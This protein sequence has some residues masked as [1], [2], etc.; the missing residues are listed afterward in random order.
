[1]IGTVNLCSL[2]MKE[3]KGNETKTFAWEPGKCLK[4]D[5][6]IGQNK[7]FHFTWRR[8]STGGIDN[9]VTESSLA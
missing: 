2:L 8:D 5:G 4:D 3:M 1:M 9:I 6:E 7:N